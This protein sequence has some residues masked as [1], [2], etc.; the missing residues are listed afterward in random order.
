M[1]FKYF[2]VGGGRGGRDGRRMVGDKLMSCWWWWE[3]W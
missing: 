2:N 1:Y 3:F